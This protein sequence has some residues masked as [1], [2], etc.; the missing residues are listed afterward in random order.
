LTLYKGVLFEDD[1]N[2]LKTISWD[3]LGDKFLDRGFIHSQAFDVGAIFPEY[4][5]CVISAMPYRRAAI[6]LQDS[7]ALKIKKWISH[8]QP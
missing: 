6:W 1:L 3:F 5:C 8:K 2:L 7:P 4:F